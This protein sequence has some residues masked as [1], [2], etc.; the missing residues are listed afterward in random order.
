MPRTAPRCPNHHVFLE[1]TDTLGIGICPISGCEFAYQVEL[2]KGEE[3]VVNKIL[4]GKMVEETQ[5]IIKGD[6]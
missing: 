4:N 5:Y 1:L 3:K 2:E 6:D